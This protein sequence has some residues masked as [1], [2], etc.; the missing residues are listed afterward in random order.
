MSV[1]PVISGK[2]V[3]FDPDKEVRFAVVIYGGMSLAIYING[4]VQEMLHFVRATAPGEDLSSNQALLEQS[5]LF[6]SE[7][8]YRQL[9]QILNDPDHAP[10]DLLNEVEH[11]VQKPIRTRFVIDILSGTSAGGL[12]AILLAKAL[13]N[14]Q[15]LD[16]V[17]Q[18]WLSQADI[19]ELINDKQSLKRES[20]KRRLTQQI[21]PQSLLNSN[22]L[23]LELLNAL[24]GMDAHGSDA[25]GSAQQ[26][27]SS[28]SPLVDELD[29]FST[30]TDING[31][32]V[33]LSLTDKVVYE[34]RHKCVFHFRY[35][36]DDGKARA[37][38]T[39]TRETLPRRAILSWPSSRDVP[40]PFHSRSSQCSSQ[41]SF[42]L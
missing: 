22:R 13:A 5:Q 3:S 9:G 1:Q 15:K 21:P 25:H 35:L 38:A 40:R 14:N 10:T 23:Y 12:N 42:R 27:T 26:Q 2:P 7:R 37:D 19:Q 29:L 16:A 6:S 34:R 31:L 28:R 20:L 33:P 24:D 41:T 36:A 30:T 4:I 8:V 18:L 39:K 17:R 11:D 32:T